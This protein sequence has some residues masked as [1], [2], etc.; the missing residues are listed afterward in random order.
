[1]LRKSA[2]GLI[3]FCAWVA[4]LGMTKVPEAAAGRQVQ[5]STSVAAPASPLPT[6][7]EAKAVADKYCVGCHNERT[8]A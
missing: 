1:M 5:G 3:A 2:L 8:S 6:P 4:A 7:V